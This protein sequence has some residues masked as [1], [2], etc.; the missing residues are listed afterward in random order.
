MKFH[1]V[2]RFG[3]S[4]L[5]GY[6]FIIHHWCICTGVRLMYFSTKLL[7]A[8]HLSCFHRFCLPPYFSAL[9]TYLLLYTSLVLSS[10]LSTSV[11]LIFCWCN[12]Y[13]FHFH[14]H[15][16]S[17]SADFSLIYC[18]TTISLCTCTSTMCS[19][20]LL[21]YIQTAYINH[22]PIRVKRILIYMN[23]LQCT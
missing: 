2:G 22:Q 10:L 9:A 3:K 11:S 1:S 21:H 23:S 6:Q 12:F 14:F 18:D 8:M 16:I 13:H 7:K 20:V 5:Y 17:S 15:F 4:L 19:N